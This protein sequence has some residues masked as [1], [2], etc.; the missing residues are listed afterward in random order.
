VI[1]T[2][3]GLYI[4]SPELAKADGPMATSVVPAS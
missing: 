3:A 4:E 1:N 2:E